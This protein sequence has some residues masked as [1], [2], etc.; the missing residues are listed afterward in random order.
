MNIEKFVSEFADQFDEIDTSSF[1]AETLFK[2]NDEWNSM[3]ALSVI[4]MVDESYAVRLIGDDV[5]NSKTIQ[6]VYD[7]VL[8]KSNS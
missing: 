2:E 1:T 7:I 5:R 3:T 8:T 4:A 6:D